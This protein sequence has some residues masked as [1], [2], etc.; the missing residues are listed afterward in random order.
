MANLDYILCLWSV[1][2]TIDLLLSD[3]SAEL[4][5]QDEN[6]NKF[7]Y[8]SFSNVS[9]SSGNSQC[10]AFGG[11]LP[12]IKTAGKQKFLTSAFLYDI[13]IGLTTDSIKYYI[14]IPPLEIGSNKYCF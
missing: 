2:I 10:Q 6:M 12:N 13:W 11:R 7:Y 3:Q 14:L 8:K 4:V 5:Y 9:W 1:V